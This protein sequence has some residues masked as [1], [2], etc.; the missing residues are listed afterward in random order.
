MIIFKAETDG[1]FGHMES[2]NKRINQ[3]SEFETPDQPLNCGAGWR[4]HLA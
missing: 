2:E 3:E 4:D 1:F